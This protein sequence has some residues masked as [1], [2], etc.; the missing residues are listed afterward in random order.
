MF[1]EAAAG[2]DQCSGYA[3]QWFSPCGLI[4]F[5][6]VFFHVRHARS[7]TGKKDITKLVTISGG[8]L[9]KDN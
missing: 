7:A 2:E 5:L 8:W 6:Y 1:A 9:Q 4:A 3:V